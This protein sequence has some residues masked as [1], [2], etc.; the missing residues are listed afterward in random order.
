MDNLESRRDELRYS[1]L[2]TPEPRIYR[3]LPRV[4]IAMGCA[5]GATVITYGTIK[6]SKET[7]MAGIAALVSS[8]YAFYEFRKLDKHIDEQKPL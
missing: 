8:A 4:L 1:H 6:D 5:V 2:R 3:I 7:I